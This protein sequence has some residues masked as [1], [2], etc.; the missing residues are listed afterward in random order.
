MIAKI[1][2]SAGADRK[3]REGGRF[4]THVFFSDRSKESSSNSSRQKSSSFGLFSIV[5]AWF[6]L[7]KF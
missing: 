7:F 2:K 6:F 3:E 5:S 1:A 4:Q